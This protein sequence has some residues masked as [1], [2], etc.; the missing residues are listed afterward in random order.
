MDAHFTY[1]GQRF[2]W[3]ADKARSNLIKHGV[4]FEQACEVFF[5]PFMQLIDAAA[6][7]EARDA[8]LGL[9]EDWSLL[10]VVHVVRDNDV[11]RIVSARCATSAERRLYEDE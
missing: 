7:D 4:R 10:L 9:A 1:N 11:I 6:E 5:D 2:R 3:D 8:A